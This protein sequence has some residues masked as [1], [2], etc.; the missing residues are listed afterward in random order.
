[1]GYKR[2]KLDVAWMM[3]WTSHT[4]HDIWQLL[5]HDASAVSWTVWVAVTVSVCDSVDVETMVERTVIVSTVVSSMVTNWVS[6]LSLTDV[7][8][9]VLMYVVGTISVDTEVTVMKSV[10]VAVEVISTVMV[11]VWV[12]SMVMNCVSVLSLTD[13]ETYVLM[14]VV[15]TREV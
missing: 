15:G 4:I 13:V 12:S 5:K 9:Y 3:W 14:Y 2:G 11:S 10:T 1:M 6:V 7:E 8:T